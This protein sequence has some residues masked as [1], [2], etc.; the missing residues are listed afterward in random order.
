MDPTQIRIDLNLFIPRWYQAEIWDAI[1]NK[2]Y[3]KVLAILPRRS[4]KD[5]T[6]WNLAIRQC[7]RKICQ[8]YY[9]LPTYSQAKKAIFDAISIDSVKFLDFIPKEVIESI[10]TQEQKIRFTNGSILQ[11]VGADSYNTS[12]VGTNPFGIVL[13]EFSL[14]SSEVYSFVRPIIAANRGWVCILSTPRGKNHLWH[15]F[16]TAQELPDWHVIKLGT[17]ETQHIEPD[18]LMEEKMSMDEGLYLQEYEVSFERGIEGS[19]FGRHLDKLRLSGQ[20]GH[21]P[22][23][24]GLLCYTS[25][26]I[27]VNDPTTIVFFQVANN[28]NV[29]SIIDCYSNNGLGLDHYAKVIQDKPYR[30]GAHYAPHDIKVREVGNQAIT[31]FHMA[32]RLGINFI[33]LDQ[34]PL[35][36]SIEKVWMDFSKFW[37][38]EIKCKSLIDALENYRK[39]WNEVEQRYNPKPVKSWAN[40]YSDA[41]RYMCQALP[42]LGPSLTS[43]EFLRQKHLALYGDSDLPRVFRRDPR[44]DGKVYR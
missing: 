29:V 1:E 14:M 37:I 10:N 5:I 12:L 16:K 34:M 36:D 27:G 30:Y 21:V 6:A 11:C 17:T 33:C 7:L 26:D 2:G 18:V 15:L 4:G 32:E 40:H 3:H 19:F 42:E 39:E 41:V 28:T 22:W 20:I 23:N 38:D 43:D 24:P 9:C 44:Y 25:W 8:V 35:L 31:R 13:S